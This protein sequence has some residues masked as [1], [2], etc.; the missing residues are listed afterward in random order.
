M[1][2]MADTLSAV[3]M[4]ETVVPVYREDHD[5]ARELSAGWISSA[6]RS[7]RN[8]RHVHVKEPTIKFTTFYTQLSQTKTCAAQLQHL[9]D[10]MSEKVYISQKTM[11]LVDTIT[12]FKLY[13]QHIN[14]T[15]HNKRDW[16][17]IKEKYNISTTDFITFQDK[18][19]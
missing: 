6:I 14:S 13:E 8:G 4:F 15:L 11:D 1:A 7:T 3:D 18:L 16:S 10:K 2:V 5:Y 19:S 9:K 12:T 17:A